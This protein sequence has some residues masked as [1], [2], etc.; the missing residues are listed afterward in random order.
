MT[1]ATGAA[2]LPLLAACGA[3]STPTASAPTAPAKGGAD[4]PA[5]AAAPA[6]PPAAGAPTA[7]P[8]AAPTTAPTGAA[9]AAPAAQPTAAPAGAAA[10]PGGNILVMG[11]GSEIQPIWTPLRSAAGEVQVFDLIYNR[12]LAP[13]EKWELQP[14]LAEKF[15]ISPDG[16]V[17]TFNLRKNVTWSDGKPFSARDVIFTYRLNLTKAAGSRQAARLTQ[18]KGGQDFFDGKSKEI[19]GLE[20]LD[21]Y[22]VRITLDNPNVGWLYQATHSSP[23]LSILP[24]H[25]FK[26]L[27][28]AQLESHPQVKKPD[29]GTG[30]YL[31]VQFV[32]DQHIEFK[33]NPNYFKGA[34]K[35]ERVFI[36]LAEPPTQLAQLERGE[37]DLMQKVTVK[38]AERLKG[39]QSLTMASTPGIGVFQI[40][41]FHDRPYFKDKRVR[42]AFMYGV[43][44]EALIKVVLRGEGRLVHSTVIGPDW[45]NYPDLN[46]YKYDPAKAKELLKA[47]NWDSSR[48]VNLTWSKGFQDIELA[49]PIVQQQLKE[50]GFELELAPL[51][52]PAYVKKVVSEPDFDL[53]WFSGGVYGLDPDISS[54]YYESTNWTPR[55]ANTTHY[56]NKELDDLFAQGRATPDVAK[57]KEIYAKVA[58]ILNEDIPSIFWWSENIIWGVNKRVKNIKPGVNQYIWW[59]IQEWT[60]S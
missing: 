52:S 26:D 51:D 33:A 41:W 27:D 53:A 2:A 23:M 37:L 19:P 30:P 50:V 13:N 49:A 54:A 15:Q 6:Q 59:N 46:P 60:L 4:V 48:K 29:V 44:R 14:D 20:M 17:Y 56:S 36:R 16:K 55:G 5:K 39:S 9:A 7:A 21:D 43:D 18:I 3:P 28:P 24:E 8:A 12:L 45:A 1:L 57:R 25:V 22:T 31:F 34:P 42:Q 35:I 58:K 32:A 10:K 11:R 47:A 38:D 40:A